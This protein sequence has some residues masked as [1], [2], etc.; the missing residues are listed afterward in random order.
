MYCTQERDRDV[1]PG[2]CKTRR[3]DDDDGYVCVCTASNKR[4]HGPE[5]ERAFL[6][7]RLTVVKSRSRDVISVTP[8]ESRLRPLVFGAGLD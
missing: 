2:G 6:G 1:T 3:G 7:D 8:T 5:L 4:E